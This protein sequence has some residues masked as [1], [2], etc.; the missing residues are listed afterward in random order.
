MSVITGDDIWRFGYR[1]LA[2]ALGRLPG[3]FTTN[4]RNYLYLGVRGFS[5][6]GEYNN[7]ILLLLDG[8]R[9]NN[10][11]YGQ[12]PLSAD[13]PV[14]SSLIDRIEVVR[15]PAS[16][17]YGTSACFGVVNVI[18]R[19]GRDVAGVEPSTRG[20]DLLRALLA[21]IQARPQ[22]L[23]ETTRIRSVADLHRDL[24]VRVLLAEDN[25]VNQDVARAMLE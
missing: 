23:I 13:F 17:L 14:D 19:R 12:A 4:D 18:T 9:L 20:G 5:G 7:R 11:V 15:G 2:E 8:H 6:A 21:A 10:P 22:S 1:T 16:S 24:S 25:P 3:F